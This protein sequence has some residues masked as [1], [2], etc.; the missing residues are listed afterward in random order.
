MK[1][2]VIQIESNDLM[3][4][5]LSSDEKEANQIGIT[6]ALDHIYRGA[7]EGA[8]NQ[9]YIDATNNCYNILKEFIQQHF[10]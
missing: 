8:N 7:M 4:T 5:L 3:N 10:Q 1:L 6:M 9:S 2:P